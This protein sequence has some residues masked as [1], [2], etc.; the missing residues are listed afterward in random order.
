[1]VGPQP[2]PTVAERRRF[3]ALH[4]LGCIACRLDGFRHI[5]AEIH[6]LVEGS[7]RL[8]HRH[9]LPL[10]PTHHRGVF[11][12]VFDKL[13]GPSLARSKRDFVAEYGT[14]RELLAR[15]DKLIGWGERQC[16]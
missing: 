5:P 8:G 12:S 10:C 7:R 9:T 14:E 11:E 13:K 16:T 15:V 6:H 2:A 4:E 1:M 3:D